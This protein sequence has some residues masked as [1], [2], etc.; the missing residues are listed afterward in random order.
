MTD[1]FE[2]GTINNWVKKSRN[3]PAIATNF[4]LDLNHS[5]SQLDS[6]RL[7]LRFPEF[8]SGS[9]SEQLGVALLSVMMLLVLLSTM[10]IYMAEEQNL[11]IRRVSNMREAE[12][13][14]QIAT[15]GEQWA[16]KLLE[17]DMVSDLDPS[18]LDVDHGIEDW[19]NLGPP[20]KVEGTE[21]FMQVAIIDEQ[22][23]FNLNNL[24]LGKQPVNIPENNQQSDQQQ[25]PEQ[26]AV[27]LPVE[28]S[29][30]QPESEQNQN[31]QQSGEEQEQP[32]WYGVFQR[33]LLSLDLDPFLADVIIDWVDSDNT[34]TGTTGAEDQFY[35]SLSI[36]YRSANRQFNSLSELSNLRGFNPTIISILA[37]YVTTL[38]LQSESAYTRINVNTAPARVLGALSDE[39]FVT[40]DQYLALL[41][42]REQN[43][44]ESVSDFVN[45]HLA[46]VPVPLATGIELFLDVKSDYFIS[47]SCAQTGNVNLSQLSLLHKN[48]SKENVTV[49]HRQSSHGCPEFLHAGIQEDSLEQDEIQSNDDS[50]T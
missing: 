30:Q 48:R 41:E 23:K 17:R 32:T 19:A 28:N 7:V 40:H 29:E 3:G 9:K 38:P 22:G 4:C 45:A 37:P 43:P 42:Y 21:S 1:Q 27:Q 24:L 15:G 14:F 26:D 18:T 44:F 36:P 20:V 50:E 39:V 11:A 10:A 6:P 47:R 5:D 46:N 33:L 8:F 13:A 16:T 25:P 49:H 2:S 35:S 12:Q 34:T 31:A